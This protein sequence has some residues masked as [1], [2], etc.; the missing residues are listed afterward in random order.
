[1]WL[2]AKMMTAVKED[3]NVQYHWSNHVDRLLRN[4]AVPHLLCIINYAYNTQLSII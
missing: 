3:S 2:T 1:M 4:L